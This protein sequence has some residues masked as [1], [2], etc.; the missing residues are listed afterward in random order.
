MPILA[1]L[2]TTLV[3]PRMHEA[4]ALTLDLDLLPFCYSY[5]HESSALLQPAQVMGGETDSLVDPH[6]AELP[7]SATE[8]TSEDRRHLHRKHA[9][10]AGGTG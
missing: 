7:T 5:T 3:T 1:P 10:S 8:P 9:S 4:H 6:L 2:C